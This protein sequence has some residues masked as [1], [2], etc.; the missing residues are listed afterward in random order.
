VIEHVFDIFQRGFQW[1]ALHGDG[2]QFWSGIGSGSP[3]IAGVYLAWRRHNCHVRGCPR[4]IWKQH[5][6][7]SLCRRHHPHDAPTADALNSE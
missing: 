3:L 6:D 4:V 2:Y 7:H 5:G 1:F